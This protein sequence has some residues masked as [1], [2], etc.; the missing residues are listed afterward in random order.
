MFYRAPEAIVAKTAFGEEAMNMRVPFKISAKGMENTDKTGSEV[1]GFIEF[2]E[3]TKDN[4]ADSRKKAVKEIAVFEEERAKFFGDGKDT[5][6][7][8]DIKDF[9]GHRG[10]T[11]DRVPVATG[12]TESAFAAKRNEFP[13]VAFSTAIHGTA[14]GRIAAVDHLINVFNH[15]IPWMKKI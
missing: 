4:T 8:R 3:H 2:E 15:G 7:V 1:F 10:S 12:R 14:I 5:V 9:G 6:T 13:F 11:V